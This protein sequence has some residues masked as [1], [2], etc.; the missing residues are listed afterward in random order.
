VHDL[1]YD[2][3]RSLSGRHLMRREIVEKVLAEHPVAEAI[4]YDG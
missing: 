1:A 2:I 3:L 4:I